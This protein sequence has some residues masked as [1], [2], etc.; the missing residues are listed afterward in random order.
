[1]LT[2]VF[3][4]LFSYPEETAAEALPHVAKLLEAFASSVTYC[5]IEIDVP[6]LADRWGAQLAAIPQMAAEVERKSR[7]GAAR[8]LSSATSIA[9]GFDAHATTLR[10]PFMN[11]GIAVAKQARNHDITAAAV[12]AGSA[13][14]RAISEH[15]LFGSGRPL[16]LAPMDTT[17]PTSLDQVA[18]AWD[19]GASI[20]RAVYDAMPLIMR[21]KAVVVLTAPDDKD[22][23]ANSIEA[24]VGYLQRHAVEPRIAEADASK[25][26]V[27]HD[28]Q[29]A[30][31]SQQ[32]DLLVMGAY[33][34]SRLREFI[35]GG[36]T[37]GVLGR[38]IMPVFMS[39]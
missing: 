28:L 37:A 7:E 21:A 34:H 2:D 17:L 35:L 11:T 26:G 20:Y 3:V 8:L 5:G 19:G 22:I 18:I 36:A 24:L 10:A 39:R 15:I 9:V 13:D 30:A 31:L 27:A 14:G 4:P 32:A 16:L 29:T 6:D 23:A 38:T 25:L 12:R 33:G 1:M